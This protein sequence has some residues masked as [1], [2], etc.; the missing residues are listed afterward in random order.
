MKPGDKQRKYEEFLMAQQRKE[1]AV[2]KRDLPSI[3]EYLTYVIKYHPA[4]AEKNWLERTL[5]QLRELYVKTR[6]SADTNKVKDSK[7]AIEEMCDKLNSWAQ[8]SG[9]FLYVEHEMDG[10]YYGNAAIAKR[11]FVTF[12]SHKGNVEAQK[13]AL[14][15]ISEFRKNKNE[16]SKQQKTPVDNKPIAY[17]E[18]RG[19]SIT[20]LNFKMTPVAIDSLKKS[21]AKYGDVDMSFFSNSLIVF[22]D[23]KKSQLK[24]YITSKI[25]INDDLSNIIGK[26]IYVGIWK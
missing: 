4:R 7:K 6:K 20:V 11:Y 14:E 15:F 8:G 17:E 2:W 1:E 25:E 19:G 12:K 23:P 16:K 3:L 21:F 18:Y 10:K 26:T 5:P 9:M 22:S 24:R 13:D